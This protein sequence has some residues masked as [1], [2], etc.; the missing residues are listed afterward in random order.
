MYELVPSCPPRRVRVADPSEAQ[1]LSPV[2]SRVPEAPDEVPS[3]EMSM[4]SAVPRVLEKDDRTVHDDAA[5]VPFRHDRPD[6]GRADIGRTEG[7]SR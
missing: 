3:P 7:A 1:A 4:L 2:V 5:D 6:T